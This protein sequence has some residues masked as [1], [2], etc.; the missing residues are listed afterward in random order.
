MHPNTI[1]EILLDVFTL[2]FIFLVCV[3]KPDVSRSVTAVVSVFIT[4]SAGGGDFFFFFSLY[5]ARRL[6][7]PACY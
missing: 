4:F 6:F 1:N 5:S 7:V 3:C 2:P